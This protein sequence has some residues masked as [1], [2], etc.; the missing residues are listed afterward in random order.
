MR[1]GFRIQDSGFR[2]KTLLPTS[3]FLLP[4]L[5]LSAFCLL[6]FAFPQSPPKADAPKSVESAK[7]ADTP[8]ALDAEFVELYGDYALIRQEIERIETASGQ[9]TIPQSLRDLSTRA[10]AKEKKMQV[11]IVAHHVGAG[12]VLNWQDKRFEAPGKEER[13]GVGS[14]KLEVG[15]EK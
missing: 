4:L 8:V 11:W 7:S 2:K 1:T 10:Q 13:A 12:W 15:R 14:R 5:L 6:P 9:V 3:H